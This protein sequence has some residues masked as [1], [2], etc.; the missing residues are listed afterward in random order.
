MRYSFKSLIKNEGS[1]Y[2][3]EIPFNV[4]E[5]TGLKGNIPVKVSVNGIDFECKLLPKGKGYYW[6]LIKK[7]IALN[8]ENE[9]EV[10]FE[11]IASLSRI[12]HDSPYSRE[13]P[14]RKIDSIKE[15][16]ITTGFCGHCCVAMLAGVALAEVQS[17]MGKTSASWS[18][19]QETLDYY[20]ITY[21]DKMVYPKGKKCVLP[22]CCIAYINGVFKLWFDGRYYGSEV[23]EEDR[24]VSYLEILTP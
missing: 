9:V 14:I 1:K 12:N 15:I 7:A 11:P 17:V 24:I 16:G 19:I 5:E 2:Y 21:G 23:T 10:S 4:W 8:L 22:R 18:K 6:I 13:N 3:I 20:G